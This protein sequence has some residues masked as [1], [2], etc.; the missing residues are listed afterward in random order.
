MAG[1]PIGMAFIGLRPGEHGRRGAR[2]PSPPPPGAPRAAMALPRRI[3]LKRALG[4][5][6]FLGAPEEPTPERRGTFARAPT[7]LEPGRG[8]EGRRF[9][10]DVY[11]RGPRTSTQGP[12]RVARRLSLCSSCR[13]GRQGAMSIQAAARA[14]RRILGGGRCTIGGLTAF[15]RGR[16]T[17]TR[18]LRRGRSGL[19][20]RLAS[21]SP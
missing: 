7:P 11:A 19:A 16:L 17:P 18:G 6:S 20:R 4:R 2:R 5:A 10:R 13:R 9:L 14:T 3:S 12:P 1:A 8:G 21:S 15:L